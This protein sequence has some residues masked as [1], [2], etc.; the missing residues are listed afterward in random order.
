MAKAVYIMGSLKNPEVPSL[1]ND[2]QSLGVEAFCDWF[3][4]GPNADDHWRDYS[5]ARGLTYAEALQSYAA[6]HIFE[7]DKFHLDRCDAGVLLMPAGKS[8]HLEFGYMIGT[9]KPGYMLIEAEE[10][11]WDIMVQFATKIFFKRS[12]LLAELALNFGGM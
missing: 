10:P 1:A 11:R 6:T 2:I 4:P 7:F 5:K 3:S 8:A 12:S 9:G